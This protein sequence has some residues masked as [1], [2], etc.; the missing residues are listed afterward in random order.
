MESVYIERKKP[1]AGT[2]YFMIFTVI[3]KIVKFSHFRLFI[4]AFLLIRTVGI[5]NS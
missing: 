3:L 2:N 4:S 5:T 1:D